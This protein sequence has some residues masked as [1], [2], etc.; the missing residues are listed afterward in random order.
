VPTRSVVLLG[1]SPEP[2]AFAFGSFVGSGIGC[3]S[4]TMSVLE[5]S[6]V[7]NVLLPAL[8]VARAAIG[9]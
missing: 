7:A 6:D 2:P 5:P 4:W 8:R 9:T 3:E 1:P